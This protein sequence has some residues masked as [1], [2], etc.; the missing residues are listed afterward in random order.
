MTTAQQK[1]QKVQRK[2]EGKDKASEFANVP[3]GIADIVD[4]RVK[5]LKAPTIDDILNRKTNLIGEEQ[6]DFNLV[7]RAIGGDNNAIDTIVAKINSYNTKQSQKPPIAGV[8]REDTG[9]LKITQAPE[10]LTET[11]KSDYKDYQQN[12][13][14]IF[15]SLKGAKRSDGSPMFADEKVINLLTKYYSSGEFFKETYRQLAEI[16]RAISQLPSLASMGYNA[17]SSGLVAMGDS[18]YADEWAKR[19]PG[20]AYTNAVLKNL[21]NKFG[22]NTTFAESIDKE[23]TKR[24]IQD[25]GQ[26]VYNFSYK[27]PNPTGGEDLTFRV[28]DEEQGKYL[29]DYGFGDLPYYEQFGERLF[30]NALF[31]V[32]FARLG[33]MKGVKDYKFVQQLRKNQ[34]KK[35]TTDMTDIEVLRTYKLNKAST[36]FGKQWVE[37]TSNMG[38]RF[39][40]QGNVGNYTGNLDYNAALKSNK[41]LLEKKREE[42]L[43]AFNKRKTPKNKIDELRG[44]LQNLQTVRSQLLLKSL[45]TGDR[46]TVGVLGA[47]LPIAFYQ[48]TAGYFHNQLGVSRDVAEL[49]GIVTGITG[50]PQWL[51]RKGAGLASK[52]SSVVLGPVNSIFYDTAKFF[53]DAMSLPF[54]ISNKALE[55]MFNRPF[56]AGLRGILVDRR[57]D[58]LSKVLGRPLSSSETKSFNTLATVMKE[59]PIEQR[60]SVFKALTDYKN[61]RAKILKMFDEGAE[62]DEAAEVFSLTFAHASGL[63]PLM[64]IDRLSAVKINPNNPDWKNLADQQL[65]AENIM[66]IAELGV[67]KLIKMIQKKEKMNPQDRAFGLAFS[68]GMQEAVDGHKLKMAERRQGLLDLMRSYVDDQLSNPNVP[69]PDDVITKIHEHNLMMRPELMENANLARE[70]LQSTIGK[71]RESLSKRSELIQS[72]RAS[73]DKSFQMGRLI[74]DMYDAHIESNYLLGKSFY[75][76]AEDIAANSDPVDVTSIA[77][78]LVMQTQ[79]LQKA[80]LGYFFSSKGRF[81]QG[82]IGKLQLRAFNSMAKRALNRAGMDDKYIEELRRYFGTAKDPLDAAVGENASIMEIALHLRNN[83]LVGIDGKRQKFNVNP[84]QAS[85]FELEEMRRFFVGLENKA[86]DDGIKKLYTGFIKRIDDSFSTNPALNSAIQEA[87]DNY[88]DLIFDPKRQGSV[89]ERI[90]NSRVGPERIISKKGV[91]EDRYR[92]QYV[93]GNS[94]E[95]WHKDIADSIDAVTR[96]DRN[97]GRTLKNKVQELEYYWADRGPTGELVFDTTTSHGAAKLKNL[98]DLLKMQFYEHWGTM[99]ENLVNQ[100]AKGFN[101]DNNYDALTSPVTGNLTFRNI[102]R[103]QELNEG[104]T[105]D[106]TILTKGKDGQIRKEKVQLLDLEDII[107]ADNDITNL[108]E[109]S[110]TA[111]EEYAKFAKELNNAQSDVMKNAQEIANLRTN[112][113][114]DLDKLV[115]TKDPAKFFETVISQSSVDDVIDL[116]QKFVLNKVNFHKAQGGSMTPNDLKQV[117]LQAELEFKEGMIYYI[118]QGLLDRAGMSKSTV[119]KLKTLDGSIMPHTEMTKAAQFFADIKNDKNQEILQLFFDDQHIEYIEDLA[120]FML[121]ASGASQVKYGAT[122]VIRNISPNELISRAFNLARGMVGLPYVG[123]ELGVRLAASKN[124]ELIGLALRN[125]DA[126]LIIG[127]LLEDPKSVSLEEVKTFGTLVKGHIANELLTRGVP[128]VNAEYLP[129]DEMRRYERLTSVELMENN[130]PDNTSFADGVLSN[131]YKSFTGEESEAVQ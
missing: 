125:K 3:V 48:S 34:P 126:A 5:G 93:K 69:V 61:T 82:K 106:V 31:S 112:S 67:S 115:E 103:L 110:K 17:V 76:K 62:R 127:K 41:K 94:P 70:S 99:R 81:F 130:P 21:Y 102:E 116:R 28:I 107:A 20:M 111:R 86:K 66:S 4:P 113:V 77:E 105:F 24:Y 11:Q 23:M 55:K 109:L 52:V 46:F 36:R 45:G 60:E 10:G 44:E 104:G 73:D 54:D 7:D 9:G 87:R 80:D 38:R 47:E 26:N 92:F 75:K 100:I 96:G 2:L 59:M 98:Q 22:L 19:K 83:G 1:Y 90:E 121:S 84:F 118:T 131:I 50:G 79:D 42:F 63:A 124:I 35:Y 13:I 37:W 78:K 129:Q 43:I 72:Y 95:E 18:T 114:R 85:P 57:F 8:I 16:P 33:L 97:A 122:G 29:L 32:P 27:G 71:L 89:G 74:E 119:K 88:R 53:E 65:E 101:K 68:K 91:S 39:N 14:R 108:L 64:A 25:E 56:S 51:L 123:A 6:L 15:N 40:M 128:N 117:E 30:E 12:R 49:G 58:E 120:D